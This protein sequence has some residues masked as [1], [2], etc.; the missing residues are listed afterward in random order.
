MRYHTLKTWPDYFQRILEG[1][2]TAE[3]RKNDRDFRRGDYLVL[4][5]YKP[6]E[7]ICT[8]RILV[9]E[10]TDIVQTESFE[11]PR[12]Y[13]VMSIRVCESE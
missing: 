8:G 7:E 4:Y 5:E 10:V 11:M 13:C 3:W 6:R 9:A 12:D 1:R 2:K